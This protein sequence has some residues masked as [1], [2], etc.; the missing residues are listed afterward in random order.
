MTEYYKREL[1]ANPYLFFEARPAIRQLLHLNSTSIEL[2]K[3]EM[4]LELQLVLASFL[5]PLIFIEGA[6]G[7]LA[8]SFCCLGTWNRP[9]ESA[10]KL[11]SEGVSRWSLG[12]LGRPWWSADWQV[13]P[14]GPLSLQEMW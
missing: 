11:P 13:G 9:W 1:V 7:G 3:G 6:R 14:T 5:P 2:L 10:R 4:E 12:P 8:P